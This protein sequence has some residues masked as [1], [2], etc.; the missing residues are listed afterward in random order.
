MLRSKKA[1]FIIVRRITVPGIL[2][3]TVQ[4]II[5]IRFPKH[6]LL[7]RLFWS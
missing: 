6:L 4:L 3:L 7:Q 2:S 5:L 1:D